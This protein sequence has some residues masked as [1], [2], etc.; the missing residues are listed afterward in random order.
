MGALGGL[1][2]SAHSLAN[3]VG[4]RQLMRSWIIYYVLIPPQGA[5]LALILYLFLRV[6]VLSPAEAG[7]ATKNLNL[8]ALY[9]FA[10]LAGLFSKQAIEMFAAVFSTVF[11]KVE[12]KDSLQME[13]PAG[14]PPEKHPNSPT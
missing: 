6:G 3:F 1:I 13:V 14:K 5:A 9:A 4:N 12:A 2:H 7:G 11:K 8:V 10:G